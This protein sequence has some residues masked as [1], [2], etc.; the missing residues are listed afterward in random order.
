MRFKYELP[1]VFL[2]GPTASGKTDTAINLSEKFPFEIISIDSGMVYKDMDIGTCK[3]HKDRLIKTKHHLVN[4]VSPN[5][6]FDLG[7]FLKHLEPSIK[8]IK[9]REKIP[10]FV[11]GSMMYHNVLLNGFHDFPSNPKIRKNLDQEFK[12]LGIQPLQKKLKSLDPDLFEIIDISN[13][14]RLIRALE[15]IEIT[16][17]KMSILREKKKIKF[18][19]KANCLKIGIN[20]E[21][22]GLTDLATR[23]LNKIL[24]SGFKE[25]LEKIIKKYR[26]KSHDQSM[27]S[28]NYKQY[29]D[30]I[31]GSK[32][33][34]Q[35]YNEALKATSLLIKSQQ[36]WLKKL[37][38]DTLID[39]KN[40]KMTQ[41]IF[42]TITE[43]Q[44][45]LIQ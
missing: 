15:I 17:K 13:P 2:I 33:F 8:E 39:C 35:A 34:E 11:G 7:V 14:R 5:D 4:L 19:D 21:K 44:R 38:L 3:P 37:D 25:E 31:V 43:Y 42:D 22:K 45:R 36:T 18:F 27:Q 1:A 23:R 29:F 20:T 24:E 30:C 10:L 9:S 16:G 12:D 6:N 40:I 32:S 28:I 41:Q 26:L